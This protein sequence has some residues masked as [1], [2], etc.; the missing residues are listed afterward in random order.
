[1]DRLSRPKPPL[2]GVADPAPADQPQQP[3]YPLAAHP[4]PETQPE[5]GVHPRAAI[6]AP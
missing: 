1:M 5:L 4:D 6:G 2:V 3:G